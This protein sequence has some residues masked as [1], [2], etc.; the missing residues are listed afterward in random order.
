MSNLSEFLTVAHLSWLMSDLSDS[1]TV[2][3]LSWAIIAHSC[4]FDL[5]DLSEWQWAN[6]QIPN[7][8]M[9]RVEAGRI[10]KA[11]SWPKL[12]TGT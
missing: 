10:L 9:P 3:H 5:S 12:D 1:L 6:E 7:P 4:S 11:W 2:A 8:V